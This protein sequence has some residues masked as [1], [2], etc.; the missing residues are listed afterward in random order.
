MVDLDTNEKPRLI[1]SP[2][3]G[4]DWVDIRRRGPCSESAKIEILD[5]R[6]VRL[7][8]LTTDFQTPERVDTSDLLPGV[9]IIKTEMCQGSYL[10]TWV[11]Q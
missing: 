5:A 7:K 6:G 3:P 1:I 11:K 4:I 8:F 2:N 10:N 9:Y